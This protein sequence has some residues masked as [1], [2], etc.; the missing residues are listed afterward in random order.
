[1]GTG[2]VDI[3]THMSLLRLKSGNFIA[4]SAVDVSDAKGPLREDINLLTDDGKRLVAVYA[5]HPFHTVHFPSFY[6]AFPDAKYY[7]T[8]RHLRKQ[9]EIPW[10]GVVTDEKVRN[11]YPDEVL[12]SFPP[13]SCAEFDNPKP[14]LT[15]HFSNLFVVHRES[16]SLFNDDCVL[17]F[18]SP[19]TRMG[20]LVW[21]LGKRHN[22]FQF[23]RSMYKVGLRH[24]A[25]A[26]RT[27]LDW[28]KAMV[29]SEDINAVATA[30][31][32]VCW[33]NGK[34]RLLDLANRAESGIKEHSMLYSMA[35]WDACEK[36]VVGG[37]DGAKSKEAKGKD[38]QKP[39]SQGAWTDVETER[40]CG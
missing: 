2:I 8:P 6:N 10:A 29:E 5:T 38:P 14:P 1:M 12:M 23:H 40:E 17:F 25:D 30:H 3:G 15:N 27:F 22:T 35:K 4:L 34:K 33:R 9:K 13:V 11:A 24:T 32:A 31:N 36:Q 20:K 37:S 16:K 18:D 26:G 39:T 19:A 7:G 28:F 21:L